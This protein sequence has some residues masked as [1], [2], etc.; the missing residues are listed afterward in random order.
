ML[1]TQQK[2]MTKNQGLFVLKSKI[3][4]I[5]WE[6]Y[7]KLQPQGDINSQAAS[8]ISVCIDRYRHKYQ[9][10]FAAMLH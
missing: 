6:K 8:S 9:F 10:A 4:Q 3:H 7:F 1:L 2:K 5:H